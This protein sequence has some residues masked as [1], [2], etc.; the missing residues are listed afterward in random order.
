M[1]SIQRADN[2]FNKQNDTFELK[3]KEMQDKQEENN[4]SLNKASVTKEDEFYTELSD[5]ENELK[6]YEKH[7][8]DKTI[9][10]NCDDPRTSNFYKY[11]VTNFKR[12]K[13]KKVIA[14]GYKNRQTTLFGKNNIESARHYEFH[15]SSKVGVN[16]RYY[17]KGDG[18]FRS[19]ECIEILKQVDIIVTN[20]PFSLFREY[21]AQVI[22]YDKKFIIVGDQNAVTYREIFSLIRDNKI[23]QGNYV[24]D[25]KFKVP[26]HYQSRSTRYWQDE[27]GQK[28]RS[29]GTMCWYTNLDIDR[30][31]EE[32]SCSKK[33][34]PKE[35]PK[36]DDYDAINVDKIKDM[37]SDYAGLMAVPI[38]FM[39]K[40]NSEQFELVDITCGHIGK[41]K[42]YQRIIIRHKGKNQ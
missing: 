12:L 7:F 11:F 39:P 5:I 19:R 38:S 31:H 33:Y 21:M 29:F 18:D 20:P 1:T 25:M 6:H 9:L 13:L 37:P 30:C 16:D 26:D 27:K 42:T 24:G 28:W 34:N 32:L 14:M 23:W 4:T 22:K 8:E 2:F 40:Y 3:T 36:F 15:L 41:R 10:C 17:L 35:Y